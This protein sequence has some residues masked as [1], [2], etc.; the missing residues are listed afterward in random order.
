MGPYELGTR[1][2]FMKRVTFRVESRDGFILPGA[3]SG[4]TYL[5]DL[6]NPVLSDKPGGAGNGVQVLSS[7][8]ATNSGSSTKGRI[9]LLGSRPTASGGSK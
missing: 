8:W 4:G 3:S 7:K 9:K 6:G 5:G 1:R 2:L